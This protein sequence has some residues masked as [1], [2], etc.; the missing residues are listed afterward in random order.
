[1]FSEILCFTVVSRS[2]SLSPEI[3]RAACCTNITWKWSLSQ[4]DY[5]L[6]K[7]QVNAYRQLRRKRSSFADFYRELQRTRKKSWK[8]RSEN[9]QR[10]ALLSNWN[11]EMM[12]PCWLKYDREG[13][14][15]KGCVVLLKAKERLRNN[16]MRN[17]EN[18]KASWYMKCCIKEDYIRNLKRFKMILGGTAESQVRVLSP[19][20]KAK[21]SKH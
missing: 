3:H 12:T 2:L 16:H 21:H 4:I 15:I 18:L 7:R 19:A 9:S 1:M 5:N 20:M 14:V 10:W 13:E 17:Y 6:V 8:C 11:R